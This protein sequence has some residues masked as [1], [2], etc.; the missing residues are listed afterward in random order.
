MTTILGIHDGHDASAAVMVDGVIVAAAQEER[1]SRL[2][3]DCGYPR[4]AVEACLKTADIDTCQIDHVALS[5]HKVNPVLTKI[6][7]NA[8]FTVADWVKEQH[9]FW[10]PTLLKGSKVKYYDIFRDRSD[11]QYEQFYPIDEILNGYKKLEELEKMLAIRK[12]SIAAHLDIPVHKIQTITHEDCHTFYAYYGSPFRGE[13]LTLTA[14]G[15]GD[16]SRA[17]TSIFSQSGR[18]ELS[19]TRDNMLGTIY[20]Y[21]TL[22]L[23]MK[24]T[25]HEYKVMGLAPYANI[26]EIEKSYRVFK[27]ILKVD[28]LNIVFDK[29]P[30]DLYFHLRKELEG[31]RFDGIAGG[32]QKFVEA[33]L[34]EWVRNVI[35]DTGL[36]RVCFSGGVAQNIKAAKRIMEID[37]L[38]DIF[39]CPAAGDTSLS[40]GACYYAMWD[41]L[42]NNGCR[43]ENIKPLRH[44]YLGPSF[45][46]ADVEEALRLYEAEKKYRISERVTAEQIADLLCQGKVIGRCSGRMEFG[47]RALGNRSI[48]ADPRKPDT[49]RKIN[50]AIKF[51]DFW[52]PFTPTI[53]AERA[54]D[55]IVNPKGILSPFM[56]MAFD[57]TALARKDLIAALHPADFTARPQILDEKH[58]AEYF[59]IIKAFEKLTGVGGLLN[60]SFNL[61]GEPVVCSPMDALHT[62]E[63]SA[64]DG[65]I[66]NNYWIER[67]G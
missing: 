60:T 31:H 67:R 23:G 14:E 42:K 34:C 15:S 35:R 21:V 52:M 48:L 64:L 16:Y 59:Q 46:D 27:P 25:Q 1:F 20:K 54:Q 58:N 63:N 8:N 62:F 4:L 56:T 32:L 57:S 36:K 61:H 43:Y 9:E 39:I 7:R 28:G 55:Y 33:L 37:E 11:F 26:K 6:K 40:V 3:V 65:L 66:L 22:I 29:K 30:P 10:K 41:Y 49:I 12:R 5:T 13:T 51:R 44:T 47:L 18:N 38:I 50:Q 19:A 53:L 2:K 24:P 45:S 17:T